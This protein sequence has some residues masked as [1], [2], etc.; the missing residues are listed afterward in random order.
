MNGILDVRKHE[1]LIYDV[2]MHKAED[3]E[4]Y[5]HKGFRVIAFEADPELVRAC[6]HR[7]EEFLAQGQLIIVEGAILD[8]ATIDADQQKVKF[9]KNDN[10]TVWGTV[11]GQWAERNAQ[12]GSS[13]TVIEVDVV[14]IAAAIQQF[15]VPHYMKI[16][17]E[18]CDMTCIKA[19]RTF[20]Q[21]PDYISLE[22]DKSSFATIKHEIEAL[23]VLGYDAFQ[24]VEQSAIPMSQSPPHPPTEGRYRAQR[25]AEGSSGLFGSEL[26]GKWMSKREILRRYRIIRLG[27]YLVGDDGIMNRHEFRGSWRLRT[28]VCKILRRFTKATVPGWYDTHARHSSAAGSVIESMP[29]SQF[30]HDG[31]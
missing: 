15:G 18:G 6:R 29:P 9:Y 13:S 10:N 17:I 30:R 3:T 31:K 24:A 12:L 21:R 14:D 7:L 26:D 2:G 28:W 27:Y 22:S 11:H 19:L 16:D 1:D 23:A 5:L 25:F 4:F 20:S 8:L